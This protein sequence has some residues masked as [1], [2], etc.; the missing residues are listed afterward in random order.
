MKTLGKLK[1]NQ[2][3]KDELERETMKVLKGGRCE[4]FNKWC[5]GTTDYDLE[6][7]DAQME[8]KGY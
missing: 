7:M 4:C 5:S 1:L 6:S 2:L 3:S 8:I